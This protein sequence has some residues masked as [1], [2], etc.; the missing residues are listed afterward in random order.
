MFPKPHSVGKPTG[1]DT[2]RVAWKYCQGTIKRCLLKEAEIVVNICT[3]TMQRKMKIHVDFTCQTF[4][5]AFQLNFFNP[6]HQY[7]REKY[8]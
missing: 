1:I 5:K 8:F 4:F 2:H 3:E 7:H 6:K